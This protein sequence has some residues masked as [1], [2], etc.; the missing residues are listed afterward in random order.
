[1]HQT[2]TKHP[3]YFKLSNLTSITTN[4][5]TTPP[6]SPQKNHPPITKLPPFITKTTIHQLPHFINLLKPQITILAPPPET[7]MFTPQ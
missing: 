3:V 7:P 2:I 1:M 5:Q 4:P 6:K